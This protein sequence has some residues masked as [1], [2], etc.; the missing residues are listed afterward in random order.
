LKAL[1]KW[2]VGRTKRG[3]TGITTSNGELARESCTCADCVAWISNPSIENDGIWKIISNRGGTRELVKA[4]LCRCIHPELSSRKD[5]QGPNLYGWECG[6]TLTC[7]GCGFDF[8]GEG[9]GKTCVGIKNLPNK[10]PALYKNEEEVDVNVW[11]VEERSGDAKQL[12]LVTKKMKI[13]DIMKKLV[14]SLPALCRVTVQNSWFVITRELNLDHLELSAILAH[15]DYSATINHRSQETVTNSIDSHSHLLVT[16]VLFNRRVVYL[17][18]GKGND[19]VD[20]V[21][22]RLSVQLFDT[23]VWLSFSKS[24]SKSKNNDVVGYITA[25]NEIID[26]YKK[27]L[28]A[29]GGELK[30]IFTYT[31]NC[32]A[33][34]RTKEHYMFIAN[35]SI[36]YEHGFAVPGFFKGVHDTYGGVAKGLLNKLEERGIHSADGYNAYLNC[37]IH[38]ILPKA[39]ANYKQEE[40]DCSTRLLRRGVY[41]VTQYNLLY[42]TSDKDEFDR[43]KPS[44]EDILFCDRSV[45]NVVKEVSGSAAYSFF[46]RGD[47]IGDLV[48]SEQVCRCDSCRINSVSTCKFGHITGKTKTIK[49]SSKKYQNVTVRTLSANAISKLLLPVVISINNKL[50]FPDD[51]NESE[52]ASKDNGNKSDESPVQRYVVFSCGDEKFQV[53]WCSS[54]GNDCLQVIVYKQ[55]KENSACVEFIAETEVKEV[56]VSSIKW[57]AKSKILISPNSISIEKPAMKILTDSIRIEEDDKEEVNEKEE[58]LIREEVNIES[59]KYNDPG[60][61]HLLQQ[62]LRRNNEFISNEIERFEDVE[63]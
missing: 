30:T 2:Q 15:S 13:S 16:V 56:A 60:N 34:F 47:S 53:G 43:L 45:K 5:P 61:F 27:K 18:D 7:R 32:G 19:I 28:A 12:T 25:M 14:E 10:C 4:C 17:K 29:N 33:Q 31:D 3:E 24:H 26:R 38:M 62:E 23:D 40:E 46:K 57:M 42:V 50:S 58:E 59:M 54:N 20:A 63:L 8:E 52:A 1:R 44:N 11:E 49:I 48:M 39:A 41:S 6:V 55:Y 51:D 35:S 36:P 9:D 21:G 37:K 22:K